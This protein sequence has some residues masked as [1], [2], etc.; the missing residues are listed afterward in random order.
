M[1]LP[2]AS[3]PAMAY[4]KVDKLQKI[5]I[6]HKEKYS[7][8]QCVCQWNRCEHQR[9]PHTGNCEQFSRPLRLHRFFRVAQSGFHFVQP[10]FQHNR[11]GIL[12]HLARTA[13]PIS[14]TKKNI[15][16][17]HFIDIICRLK[18]VLTPVPME[19][20]IYKLWFIW[21][22]DKLIYIISGMKQHKLFRLRLRL[23]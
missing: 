9:H 15:F 12:D 2:S 6:E 22:S 19:L 11:F 20:I 14:H 4:I 17:S 16:L 18:R 3:S 23:S 7:P 8:S 10:P 21:L 1:C 13:T 5:G